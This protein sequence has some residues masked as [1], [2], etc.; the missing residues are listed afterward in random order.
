[1]FNCRYLCRSYTKS[2]CKFRNT[3]DKIRST[4]I[5]NWPTATCVPLRECMKG[6]IIFLFGEYVYVLKSNTHTARKSLMSEKKN[7]FLPVSG[8]YARCVHCKLWE[9]QIV[10]CNRLAYNVFCIYFHFL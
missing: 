7:Y 2:M 4:F 1:M 10:S 8:R 9:I 6:K 3:E 5:K